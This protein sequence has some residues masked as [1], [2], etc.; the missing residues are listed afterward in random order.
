MPHTFGHSHHCSFSNTDVLQNH[1]NS[2]FSIPIQ[3][4][5]LFAEVIED[6]SVRTI[7][8]SRDEVD[9][10]ISAKLVDLQLQLMRQTG[11]DD[12]LEP[13]HQRQIATV[14]LELADLHVM[15]QFL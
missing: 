9:L 14:V 13:A 2:L 3:Y 10:A 12:H 1:L 15:V 7:A 5:E 11:S 4:L 8:I 6:L